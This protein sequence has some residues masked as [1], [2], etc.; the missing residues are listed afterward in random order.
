MKQD[1]MVRLTKQGFMSARTYNGTINRRAVARPSEERAMLNDLLWRDASTSPE[2][3]TEFQGWIIAEDGAGFWEP[4]CK[5]DEDGTLGIY[6]R[7][8]YDKDGW[9]FGLWHLRI[10][11]WMPQPSEPDMIDMMSE[12]AL[13]YELRGVITEVDS[14]RKAFEHTH[15]NNGE[16]DAC[17]ECG[18]DIRNPVHRRVL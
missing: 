9:D 11:H 18:L 2:D 4:R 10:T 1:G 3:G 8:D 17:A 13:R 5:L 7:V 16:D 15:V 14:L 6:G 12:D